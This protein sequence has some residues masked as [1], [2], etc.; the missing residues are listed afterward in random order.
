MS[1]D[2]KTSA[3][4]EYRIAALKREREGYER[5]GK[6]DRVKAV[7]AE[8]KRLKSSAS[9]APKPAASQQTR[10]DQTPARDVGQVDGQVAPEA[11][12]TEVAD[13]QK[14]VGQVDGQVA[15]DATH[16]PDADAKPPAKKAAAKKAATRRGSK[17]QG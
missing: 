17:A 12:T 7:D 1:Q 15:P 13:G 10:Q 16:Q 2:K 14:D 5:Y 8:L 3:E 11:P 4:A 6:T 9:D